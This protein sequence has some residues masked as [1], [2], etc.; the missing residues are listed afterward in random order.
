MRSHRL[1]AVPLVL[2]SLLSACAAR[3]SR[4]YAFPTGD[5]SDLRDQ[6][7]PAPQS[8]PRYAEE[9]KQERRADERDEREKKEKPS[10]GRSLVHTLLLYVP[11]R[12]LDVLD[13]ARAAVD[14]GPGTGVDLTG[15][16]Y[17]RLGMLARTSAGAGYETARHLP[18]KLAAESY[19]DVGPLGV[20]P[21]F[22]ITWYRNTWDL[23]IEAHLFI[24]GA[25]VA[26]NPAEIFDAVL[27]LTTFD[28]MGDDF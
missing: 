21:G 9:R 17:M 27:G 14:V 1:A 25:H 28:L 3:A 19:L 15:T 5:W 2:V 11:N 26:V 8:P 7:A 16:E 4:A 22:P 13:V 6:D 18:V 23:R 12:V 24:L 10:E 20:N